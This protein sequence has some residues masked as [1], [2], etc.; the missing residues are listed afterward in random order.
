MFALMPRS[1]RELLPRPVGPIGRMSE[2]LERWMNRFFNE[3]LLEVPTEPY[4]WGLAVEGLEKEVVVRAELPGF[5]PEE[6][7]VERLGNRLT[8]EAE[9]RTAAEGK[10]RTER[11][12]SR[13]RREVELPAGIEPERAEA[14]LRN[15]VL[16][17]RLPRT[18]EATARTI[19]V[20]T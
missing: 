17:V 14:V 4:P 1:M 18:P 8:I 11:E 9:H 12:V 6:I 3:P 10:E 15:G 19:E 2:E 7:K 13:V 16:E 5:T 20:K